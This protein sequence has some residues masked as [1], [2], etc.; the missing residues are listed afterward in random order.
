MYGALALV[1]FVAGC[2]CYLCFPKERKWSANAV[3]PEAVQVD[4]GGTA[5]SAQW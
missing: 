5:P 4:A 1:G 2:G 3:I